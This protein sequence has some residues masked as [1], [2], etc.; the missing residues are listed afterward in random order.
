MGASNWV[1]SI[2]GNNT[3]RQ[4]STSRDGNP[5]SQKTREQ[6]RPGILAESGSFEAVKNAES[7]NRAWHDKIRLVRFSFFGFVPGYISFEKMISARQTVSRYLFG[8]LCVL[9]FPM[10]ANMSHVLPA[11]SDP[12]VQGLAT[13]FLNGLSQ[14]TI[15]RMARSRSSAPEIACFIN[16]LLVDFFGT[17]PNMTVYRPAVGP[18]PQRRYSGRPPLPARPQVVFPAPGTASTITLPPPT[19]WSMILSCSG[20][21]LM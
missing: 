17:R 2:S 6:V 10:S 1:K 11:I 18:V 8:I 5:E 4:K 13:E 12:V 7:E 16:R 15:R 3:V 14:R 21:G 19:M 20:V 9:H